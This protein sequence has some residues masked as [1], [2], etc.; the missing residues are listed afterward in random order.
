[1]VTASEVKR[2]CMR[3][4]G[5][6]EGARSINREP[7]N[8]NRIEGATEQSERATNREALVTAVK[9][10]KRGGCAVKECVLTWGVLTSCLKE[11]RCRAGARRQQRP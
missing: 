11:R 1:M 3:A 6:G 10:R 5:C 8:K 2:N 7:M 4:T 9:R